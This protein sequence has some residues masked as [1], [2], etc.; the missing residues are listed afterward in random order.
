MNVSSFRYSGIVHP[1]AIGITPSVDK[2]GVI[3]AY[4]KAKKMVR[5]LNIYLLSSLLFVMNHSS[6]K[7]MLTT[8]STTP[9][10]EHIKMVH[11]LNCINSKD[12]Q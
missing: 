8:M 4:K 11:V 12:K 9:L 7:R 6:D 2:K 5:Y 1:H 3:F 10:T